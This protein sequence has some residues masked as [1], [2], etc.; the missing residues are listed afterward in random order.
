MNALERQD[1]PAPSPGTAPLDTAVAS[2]SPEFFSIA[3]PPLQIGRA[4]DTRDGERAQP[5]VIVNDALAREFFGNEDPLGKHIRV[6]DEHGDNPW[7]TIVGVV[8]N[9]RHGTVYQ[10]M[11]WIETPI[12]YRPFSQEPAASVH[13]LIGSTQSAARISTLAQREAARLDPAVP[14]GEGQTVQDVLDRQFLAYPRFRMALLGAFAALALLLA[15]VGL[16]GVLAQLVTQRTQEIAVRMAL[17]AHTTD[18]LTTIIR[19]GLL[20]GVIGVAIR[21]VRDLDCDEFPSCVA[22][23]SEAYRSGNPDRR[24]RGADC[25]SPPR[26]VHSCKA[27]GSRRSDDSP[28]V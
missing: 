2:I 23:R 12:L 22:L 7:L 14:V 4:F 10:E 3:G 24:F 15:V 16:Y 25:V 9:Q 21:V 6:L 13:L 17:G 18:V 1:G 27:G 11:A 5:V 20:L 28:Q 8:A 19:E 26:D